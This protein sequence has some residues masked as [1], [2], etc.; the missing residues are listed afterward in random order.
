VHGRS[1]I[2]IH[3]RFRSLR[4]Y[5]LR[6]HPAVRRCAARRVSMPLPGPP[7]HRVAPGEPE[8]HSAPASPCRISISGGARLPICGRARWARAVAG[9]H[10]SAGRSAAPPSRPPFLDGREVRVHR[11]RFGSEAKGV[12]AGQE[13]IIR[14]AHLAAEQEA[15]TVRQ[16]ALHHLQSDLDL[17]QSMCDDL[18][19]GR[20]A[21]L[22]EDVTLV[23]DVIAHER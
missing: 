16:L 7:P 6:Q 4:R 20:D 3:R 18:F 14:Q 11:L 22:R 1:Q 5:R 2:K 12:S 9:R 15:L 21:K 8:S 23:R 19:V 13:V 10:E 17:R